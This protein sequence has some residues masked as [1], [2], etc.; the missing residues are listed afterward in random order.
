MR[1]STHGH[2]VAH[3]AS[4]DARH[5]LG[6][7]GIGTALLGHRPLDRPRQRREGWGA[8]VIP[9]LSGDLHNELPEVK[10]FSE[11][12]IKLMVQFAPRQGKA[13]MNHR[14]PRMH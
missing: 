9:R 8:S 14:T 6:Q 10:G 2:Q 13:V 11:R 3:S 7:R 4:A 5:A 12:N 1:A